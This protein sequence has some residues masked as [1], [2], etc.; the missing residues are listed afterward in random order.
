MPSPPT[1]ARRHCCSHFII[2]SP[3]RIYGR[4]S[5]SWVV[6]GGGSD[7]RNRFSRDPKETM[8]RCACTCGTLIVIT[9]IIIII[10]TIVT[11][12]TNHEER[13]A[14]ADRRRRRLIL[15]GRAEGPLRRRERIFNF[16]VFSFHVRDEEGEEIQFSISCLVLCNVDEK[17]DRKIR[18][19]RFSSK[20]CG[21][22]TIERGAS[23]CGGFCS[24]SKTES[25][26]DIG[27]TYLSQILEYRVVTD[28]ERYFAGMTSRHFVVCPSLRCA[29]MMD[30][31]ESNQRRD[32]M[33]TRTPNP[34][35]SLESTNSTLEWKC[36]SN[37]WSGLCS[38]SNEWLS[39]ILHC[40]AA[41]SS[42]TL[43]YS[44]R[45]HN[46]KLLCR[47]CKSQIA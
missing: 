16:T 31:P 25:S 12:T 6:G 27:P 34:I 1:T 14:V 20:Q 43:W 32:E 7:R 38:S 44:W 3:S 4:C 22:A 41:L 37:S 42:C 17:G 39:Y 35:L 29:K 19:P 8:A 45:F 10:I 24:H 46:F 9:H 36:Q 30:I 23:F 13:M 47:Q 2:I 26:H 28:E 11:E 18:K 33:T 5:W 15:M 21:L 40:K